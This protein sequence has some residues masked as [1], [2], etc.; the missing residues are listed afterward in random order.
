MH[1]SYYE[2]I[3]DFEEPI[4]GVGFQD[5]GGNSALRR[6]TKKNP[7]NCPCPTCHQPNRLT[8]IDVKRGYQCDQCANELEMGF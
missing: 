5:P 2:H 3:E 7:R 6:S 4:D 1:N 8:P